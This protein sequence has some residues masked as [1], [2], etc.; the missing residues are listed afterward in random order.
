M[1]NEATP[2][3]TMRELLARWAEIEPDLC[4]HDRWQDL[5]KEPRDEFRVSGK[6]AF[7]D[8]FRDEPDLAWI[9]F[10][11]QQAIVERGWVYNLEWDGEWY[12]WINDKWTG[13]D[14]ENPAKAILEAYIAALESNQ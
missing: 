5:F 6:I 12:V 11:T 13:Q 8:Q 9:Q 10:A 14:L 3:K 1:T 2:T 7:S 4:K